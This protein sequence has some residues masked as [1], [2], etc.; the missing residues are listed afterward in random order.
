MSGIKTCPSCGSQSPLNAVFCTDCGHKLADSESTNFS[1]PVVEITCARCGTNNAPDSAFC[2]NCGMKLK[3]NTQ[4]RTVAR[5]ENI[6]PSWI[7]WL[8]AFVPVLGGLIGWA[9]LRKRDRVFA[10]R[11]LILGLTISLLL[12]ANI[13]SNL[14]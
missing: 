5:I 6:K 14:R 8:L 10:S 7:W 13:V 11:I 4:T 2:D 3:T 12:F 1:L 9:M